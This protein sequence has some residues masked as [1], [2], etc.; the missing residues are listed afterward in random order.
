MKT[1]TMTLAVA[2]IFIISARGQGFVTLNFESAQNLP[3][4][5]GNGVLVP[6]ADALPGWTAYDGTL[7]LSDVYY[8]S[9]SLGRAQNA[10]L[11]GG[12]LALS[13]NNLSVGL[14]LNSSIS[15]TGLVSD[16]AESLEFE[17]QGPS[18]D[19]SIP[20]AAG[21]AVTLGGQ[22]LSYSALFAGSDYVEYGAN[23]PSAMD[24]QMEALTFGCQG[25]GSGGVL[26]DNIQFSTSPIPEP[27]ECAFIGLGAI[28]FGLRRLRK[29]YD[30]QVRRRQGYG[31]R[32]SVRDYPYF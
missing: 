8:V 20:F 3:G 7:A 6:I 21:F 28:L 4:N 5:P 23:I 24:G 14:Y 27:S 19:G 26:L 31:G 18:P 12:S 10:E 11:E 2:A 22:T 16:N 32:A 30:G 15:Q 1:I 25:P 17:A 13:G 29:G 9:N